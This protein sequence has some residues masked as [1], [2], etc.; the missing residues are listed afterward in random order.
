MTIYYSALSLFLNILLWR[1]TFFLLP[2]FLW[3]NSLYRGAR[4][5]TSNGFFCSI[6]H[7]SGG[8]VNANH[9]L[10]SLAHKNKTENYSRLLKTREGNRDDEWTFCRRQEADI[11]LFLQETCKNKTSEKSLKKTGRL[12]PERGQ[13]QATIEP[14]KTET[15]KVDQNDQSQVNMCFLRGPLGWLTEQKTQNSF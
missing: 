1:Y 15:N 10:P 13:S 14:W 5:Q 6:N 4:L 12:L 3:P 9:D 7:L 2:E 8:G 11:A